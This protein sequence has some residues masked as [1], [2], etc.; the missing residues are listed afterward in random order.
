[1]QTYKTPHWTFYSA[2]N[3]LIYSDG[4]S[5]QLAARHNACLLALLEAKGEA[6]EYDTMLLKVW[7]TLFRD[8]NTIAS[9]VSELRKHINCGN[10]SLKYIITIPKKGYRF[11]NYEEVEVLQDNVQPL[12]NIQSDNNS[13]LKIKTS[14]LTS[15]LKKP[16]NNGFNLKNKKL[17]ILG[18]FL[19][20]AFLLS[21]IDSFLSFK[22]FTLS[23]LTYE[24]GIEYDFEVSR[25]K[26]TLIYTNEQKDNSYLISKNIATG[27]KQVIKLEPGLVITSFALSADGNQ[28]A[29]IEQKEDR[30]CLYMARISDSKIQLQEKKLITTCDDNSFLFSIEFSHSTDEIFYAK[31]KD[32]SDPYTISKHDLATGLVR[33]LTSPPTTGRGDYAPALSPDGRKL[34]FIRDIYWERSSVWTL[35]LISG[36]TLKLFEFPSVIDKISWHNDETIIFTHA[37]KLLA[38]STYDDEIENILKA[39]FPLYMPRSVGGTIYSSAGYLHNAYLSKIQLDTLDVDNNEQSDYL[40]HTPTRALDDKSYYFLSNRSNKIGIW[41]NRGSASQLI[42]DSDDLA[43]ATTL[44]DAGDILLTTTPS[45]LIQID[46]KTGIISILKSDIPN[47]ENYSYSEQSKKILYSREAGESWYLESYNL[48][49]QKK[50]LLGVSGYTGHFF[51]DMIY[52]TEFREPGL[53]EY[54]PNTREKRLLISDFNSFFTNKWAVTN[55]YIFL[56]D[57]QNLKV[58]DR[59]EAYTLV[60]TIKLDDT[61]KHISCDEKECIF[62]QYRLGSTGIVSL[63]ESN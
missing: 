44:T 48:K 42:T 7:G 35:D 4:K 49:T 32:M 56:L 54:N 61:P 13:T 45:N 8:T 15:D 37:N 22:E 9:V 21:N 10:P 3:E 17:L 58:W 25:D 62:D 63:V 24:K 29:F 33:N 19:F 20:L 2:N 53:W 34:A 26:Q 46:K 60:K 50:S 16:V 36:E 5:V 1:M 47:I 18:S 40:E 28:L 12:Y 51:D 43:Y 38:Y 39:D 41:Q 31:G 6:V 57:K 55:D 14:E 52:L 30:S 23:K 11:N 27:E 59:Q